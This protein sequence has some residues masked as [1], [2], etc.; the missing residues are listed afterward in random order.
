MI[1]SGSAVRNHEWSFTFHITGSSV[2]LDPFLPPTNEAWGKVIFSQASVCPWEVSGRH[3]L[4]QTLPS[5]QRDGHWSRWYASYWNAFLFSITVNFDRFS[6]RKWVLN[7]CM[8]GNLW[9]SG[10]FFSKLETFKCSLAL[11]NIKYNYEI[12]F[13]RQMYWSF[14]YASKYIFT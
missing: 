13:L 4:G 14:V 3:P 10:A 9:I 6:N 11:P 8:V 12:L 5:P 2:N 7:M 1:K